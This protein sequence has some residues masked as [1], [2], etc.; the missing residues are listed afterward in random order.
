M[1]DTGINYT[2]L[3]LMAER[4]DAILNREKCTDFIKIILKTYSTY[5][6]WLFFHLK[7]LVFDVFSIKCHYFSIIN[8]NNLGGK[9]IF[10]PFQPMIPRTVIFSSIL[11]HFDP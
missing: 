9:K 2:F 3:E 1:E 10:L 6:H 8:D 11:C 4:L 7:K 5:F